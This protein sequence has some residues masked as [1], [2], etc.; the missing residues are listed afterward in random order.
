[1]FA[2]GPTRSTIVVL[3]TGRVRDRIL[4]WFRLT[5][6][7]HEKTTLLSRHKSGHESQNSDKTT[8]LSLSNESTT[9]GGSDMADQ[10]HLDLLRQGIQVWNAWR[11]DNSTLLPDLSKADLSGTN[12]SKVDFFRTNLNGANLTRANLSGAN[13]SRANLYEASLIWTNLKKA[14]LRGA[15][16]TKASLYE[17]DLREADLTGADLRGADLYEANLKKANLTGAM[18][19]D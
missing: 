14:S 18:M 5:T 6:C 4:T 10:Q 1:M 7:L 16:L 19:P 15:N 11:R 2:I 13:L 12:L 17:A 9:Q 8:L 3:E